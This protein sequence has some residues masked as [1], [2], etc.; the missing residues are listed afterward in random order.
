MRSLYLTRSQLSRSRCDTLVRRERSHGVRRCSHPVACRCA[1]AP[2]SRAANSGRPG[3]GT[4]PSSPSQSVSRW[5]DTGQAHRVARTRGDPA[6]WECCGALAI[7]LAVVG[8]GRL[9]EPLGTR[10]PSLPRASSG[11]ALRGR[12]RAEYALDRQ[13]RRA[14]SVTNRAADTCESFVGIAAEWLDGA[15]SRIP[16]SQMNV[17]T[18]A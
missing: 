18:L 10:G 7:E 8:G 4:G 17:R 13:H 6:R 12:I 14:I 15:H 16:V 2:T 3:G 5:A 9:D 11:L 1:R